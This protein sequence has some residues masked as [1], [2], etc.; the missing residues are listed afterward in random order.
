MKYRL[1]AACVVLSLLTAC[2]G[3]GSSDSDTGGDDGSTTIDRDNT[4]PTDPTVPT[5]DRTRPASGFFSSSAIGLKDNGADL[6]ANEGPQTVNPDRIASWPGLR[7]GDFL[8]TNNPWNASA[9]TYQA[10]YQ[11][12]SLVD[13]DNGKAPVIDWDWGASNDTNGSQ[14]NTKSYPEVIYGVKSLGE[15]SGDFATTGLPVEQY[16]SPEWTIDY[17]YNFQGRRSSSDTTGGSDS[18]FNVAIES[19]YHESCDIKRTGEP[20][21]NQV[22]EIMVWLHTGNNLPSGQAPVAVKTTSDGRRFQV[23]AK[24]SNFNYVAYVAMDET[25]S[26]TVLY[27]ELLR[28]AQDNAATYGIYPL[29]DTDCLANILMGTEIWHGAGTFTL[30]NYQINRTY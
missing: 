27:S 5:E 25:D 26:G 11:T 14:F 8:L 12:I 13:G 18:E 4:D 6:Y 29:K 30:S 17:A 28:D 15:I 22:M 1:S 20:T 9:A 24:I 10:W 7:Y 21:D 2:G 19:F 23:Y 16:D 3:G